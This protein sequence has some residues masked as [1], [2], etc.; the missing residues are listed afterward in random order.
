MFRY[1]GL[2]LALVFLSA[3]ASLKPQADSNLRHTP[4]PAQWQL[5]GKIASQ[6]IGAAIFYWHQQGADV[7]LKI[8]GP[9]GTG[10]A[11]IVRR[12]GRLSVTTPE[13]TLDHQQAQLWLLQRGLALPFEAISAWLQGRPHAELAWRWIKAPHVFEQAGWQVT[14]RKWQSQRCLRLPSSLKLEAD[15]LLLKM[16]GLRWSWQESAMPSLFSVAKS[17]ACD[18]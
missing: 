5:Q 9:L 6:G 18:S 3:C 1:L 17:D 15:G 4:L 16:A 11:R 8:N 14:I 7:E 10:A 2:L 13:Q 12:D